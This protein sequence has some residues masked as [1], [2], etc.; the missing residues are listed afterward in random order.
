MIVCVV[1]MCNLFFFKQ[2]TAYEMRISDWSSDVCSSDLGRF[3]HHHAQR[4]PGDDPV[5]AGEMAGLWF[6][7]RRLFGDQQA[8]G[9]DTPLQFLV[10]GRIDDVDPTSDPRD[11]AAFYTPLMRPPVPATPE[12]RRVGKKW[13]SP[14][15]YRW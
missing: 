15:K 6:H 1:C 4:Q 8:F 3:H 14:V 13:V 2:K 7:A 12:Q 11:R 10:L 9:R 5:A